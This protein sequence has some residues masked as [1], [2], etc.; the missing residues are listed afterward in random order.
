MSADDAIVILKTKDKFQKI[1][2]NHYK[3][4]FDKGII[5]YRVA[6]IQAMDNF[7]FYKEKESHNLG[8]WMH[9]RFSVC[10]VFYNEEDAYLKAQSLYD[11]AIKDFGY[12]AYGIQTINATDFNFPGS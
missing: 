11:K 7:E 10:E 3:K 8:Y 1:G 2:F 4:M 5:A 9:N 12:S 6:H